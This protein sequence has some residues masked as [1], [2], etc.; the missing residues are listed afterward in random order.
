M[1]RKCAH[2]GG[3]TT[4]IPPPLLTTLIYS[5]CEVPKYIKVKNLTELFL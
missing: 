1:V 5:L 4:N 3:N 2:I